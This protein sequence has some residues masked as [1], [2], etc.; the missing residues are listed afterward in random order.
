MMSACLPGVRLPTSWIDG[1]IDTRVGEEPPVSVTELTAMVEDIVRAEQA[2]VVKFRRALA[3][4]FCQD[5]EAEL[6]CDRPLFRIGSLSEQSNSHELP[7][8]RRLVVLQALEVMRPVDGRGADR[9]ADHVKRADAGCHERVDRRIGMGGAERIM[10]RVE[11][12]GNA[13]VEARQAGQ[14]CAVVHLLRPIIA[15]EREGDGGKVIIELVDVR[16]QPAHQPEPGVLMGIYEARQDDCT[17]CI[18]GPD[19]ISREIRTDRD[20]A[21]SL[22]EYVS[23]G[24]IAKLRVHGEYDAAL[25]QDTLLGSWG[26]H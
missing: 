25:E 13:G 22:D 2:F 10:A 12:A 6:A 9:L 14:H 17:R 21:V 24:E 8:R 26:S 16:H 7:A 23:P 1:H 5:A 3:N 20:N 4:E 18:E 11:N 15:P 19:S